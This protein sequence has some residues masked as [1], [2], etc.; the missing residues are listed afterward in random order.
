ML[1]SKMV[2]I[3]KE[4]PCDASALNIA[5]VVVSACVVGSATL[6]RGVSCKFFSNPIQPNPAK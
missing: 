4:K 5:H 6:E 2:S 3:D 1:S